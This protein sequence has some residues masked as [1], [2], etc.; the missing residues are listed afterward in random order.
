MAADTLPYRETLLDVEMERDGRKSKRY[1]VVV[2]LSIATLNK[3]ANSGYDDSELVGVCLVV[4]VQVKIMLSAY[5]VRGACNATHVQFHRLL[6]G[7]FRSSTSGRKPAG[8]IWY[9]VV[10]AEECMSV[11]LRIHVGGDK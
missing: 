8:G 3:L 2:R 6:G 11:P 9:Q 7:D 10:S 5:T 1:I 4:P